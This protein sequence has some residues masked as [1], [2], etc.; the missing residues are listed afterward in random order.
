M[1]KR[2][3][4]EA[5]EPEW[6][7]P[8]VGNDGPIVVYDDPEYV[9]APTL[10]KTDLATLDRALQRVSVCVAPGAPR[11]DELVARPEDGA[12]PFFLQVLDV[13]NDVGS[14]GLAATIPDYVAIARTILQMQAHRGPD[15]EIV[16]RVGA[17]YEAGYE[18][19]LWRAHEGIAVQVRPLN[20][21]TKPQLSF[22][23]DSGLT[24]AEQVRSI[25]AYLNTFLPTLLA[26]Q[27]GAANGIN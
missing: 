14:A 20:T 6:D 11:P 23:A 15:D 16:L 7:E 13:A 19:F 10:A 1:K 9:V 5:E 24:T 12:L 26:L 25:L 18:V 3:D 8:D 4:D 2:R 17:L 22:S 27:R 21:G